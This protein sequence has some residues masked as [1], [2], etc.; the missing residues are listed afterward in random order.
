METRDSVTVEVLA[1]RRAMSPDEA[2]ALEVGG[3]EARVHL[4]EPVG[5][6]RLRH[7]KVTDPG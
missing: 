2:C 4:H 3:G 1:H 7:A 5:E 6:R